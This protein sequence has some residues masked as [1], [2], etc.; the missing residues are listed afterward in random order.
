MMF[1]DS[2]NTKY[3]GVPTFFYDL[4]ILSLSLT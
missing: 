3:V 2:V 1:C 4:F